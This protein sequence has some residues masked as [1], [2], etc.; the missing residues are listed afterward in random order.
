MQVNMGG[1]VPKSFYF[2]NKPKTDIKNKKS[3]TVASGS[4]IQFEFEVKEPSS[5]LR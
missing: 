5:I 1:E 3:A 4:K 2:S